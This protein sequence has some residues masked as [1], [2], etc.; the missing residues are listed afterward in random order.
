MRK[1]IAITSF[2]LL[3]GILAACGSNSAGSGNGDSVTLK[4]AHTGSETH[5]YHIA[6]E[7][8]K[9]LAEEK[10]DGSINVEIHPNATLGS[11]AE[12]VEQV[13]GGSVEMT[14][15]AAD[16]ALS[17]TIPEMN[18]FGIPYIFEDRDHVFSVLDGEIGDELLTLAEDQGM[19]GLG[20][21]EVGFRHVTNNQ[22]EINTPEDMEGLSV[23]VQP[24]P[25]WETHMEQLG[26]SPTP[27]DFNELYSALDQGVVDGQENP[28]ATIDSMKF[29]EVQNHLALTAHAYTPAVVLM[30]GDL[31]DELNE[32][33]QAAIQSATEETEEYQRNYLEEQEEEIR[34]TLTENGVT[35]TEPDRDAFRQA[36]EDVKDA[37]DQVP[38]DLIN[39]MMEN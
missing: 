9:E 18:V 10:S 38:E 24:A 37:V 20:Y 25:V 29:Y 11:E 32:E 12:A 13:M 16:S 8:F 5:Q 28:L 30:N 15:L 3:L 34:D 26:A 22:N 31:W 4:L 23:R 17:N 33:Q 35:I 1:L 14:T 7:K 21:W 36:T 6:S 39:R 27:V 2:V 19:K